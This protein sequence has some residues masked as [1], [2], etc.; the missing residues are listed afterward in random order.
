MRKQE[1]IVDDVKQMVL[2]RLLEVRPVTGLPAKDY[3]IIDGEYRIAIPEEVLV[4]AEELV[5]K[6][7]VRDDAVAAQFVEHDGITYHANEKSMLR[8][9]TRLTT[10]TATTKVEWKSKSHGKVIITGSALKAVLKK[11]S[12]LTTI[13]WRMDDETGN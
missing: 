3:T 2:S 1:V 12:E 7:Q 11:A 5:I 8:I 6:K 13:I 9:A 4:A 10:V